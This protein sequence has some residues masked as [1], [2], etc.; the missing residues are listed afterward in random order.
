MLDIARRLKSTLI[1]NLQFT[2][3]EASRTLVRYF[4][5]KVIVCFMA[6][7]QPC[8]IDGIVPYHALSYKTKQQR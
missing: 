6:W 7:Q 5:I 2:T 1:H 4:I 3:S 8:A